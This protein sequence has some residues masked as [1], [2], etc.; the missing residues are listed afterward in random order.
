MHSLLP[1]SK[2]NQFARSKSESHRDS[3]ASTPQFA[4]V[5]PYSSRFETKFG[6]LSREKS[7]ESISEIQPVSKSNIPVPVPEIG[8]SKSQSSRSSRV[9]RLNNDEANGLKLSGSRQVYTNKELST[10]IRKSQS[11]SKAT[12][13]KKSLCDKIKAAGKDITLEDYS[14]YTDICDKVASSLLSE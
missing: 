2:E 9:P 10:D 12:M 3:T 4:K 5:N 6:T 11:G 14:V 7:F 13:H 8:P 1:S